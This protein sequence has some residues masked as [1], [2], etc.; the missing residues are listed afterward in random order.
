MGDYLL[1]IPLFLALAIGWYLGRR[2]WHRRRLESYPE[3]LKEEYFSGLNHLID[4][5]TDEAIDSFIKALQYNSET[6]PIRLALGTLFRRRG[7]I[8]RAIQLHQEVMAHPSLSASEYV[9]AQLALSRDYLAGGLLDRAESLLLDVLARKDREGRD[10]SIRLLIDI[11]QQEKEWG[12]ALDI[13]SQLSSST[14]GLTAQLAHFYCEQAVVAIGLKEW[15]EAK[16]KLRKALQHDSACVRAELLYA[17]V[18]MALGRWKAAIRHLRQVQEQDPAFVSEAVPKLAECFRQVRANGELTRFLEDS[19]Q[20]APS[21]TSMLLIAEEIARDKGDYPAGAYITD[22]LKRRPSVKGFNRLIDLHLKH[23][24]RSARE[25]LNVLRGLTGQLEQSKPDYRCQK[26]GFSGQEL[27]WQ[28]PS[29][30][31]W[32]RVKPIQGLEGE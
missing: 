10:V 13:A 7:E 6:V 27:H 28:C 25:S 14:E 24:S 31:E 30:K 8:Q 26:C 20:V 18:D 17:E 5:E 29:C 19:M 3:R 1:I 4:N 11:Y 12:K 21:T 16:Q 22:Q 23:A 2:D 9:Q 15:K 32:G